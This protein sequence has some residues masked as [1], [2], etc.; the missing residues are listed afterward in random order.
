MPKALPKLRKLQTPTAS[1]QAHLELGEE[2]VLVLIK[3]R[4][5]AAPPDYVALRGRISERLL[6]VKVSTSELQRLEADPAV[7]TFSVGRRV[8]VVR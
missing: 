1:A 7:E 8:A 6:T 5:G 2:G 4:E 3:L